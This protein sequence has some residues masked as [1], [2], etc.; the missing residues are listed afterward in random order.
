MPAE[1]MLC[2]LYLIDYDSLIIWSRTSLGSSLDPTF[3]SWQEVAQNKD[4]FP[5]ILP[6]ADSNNLRFWIRL[7]NSSTEV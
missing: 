4:Y 1:T 7:P 6:R 5:I 2:L 3:G